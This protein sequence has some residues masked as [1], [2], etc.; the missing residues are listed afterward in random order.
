MPLFGKLHK[1]TSN[2]GH[3]RKVNFH[4]AFLRKEDAMRREKEVH[5]F[6]EEKVVKGKKRYFVMTSR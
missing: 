6:I 3:G 1:H 4:G 5:G 2:V